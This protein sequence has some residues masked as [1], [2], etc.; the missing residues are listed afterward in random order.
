MFLCIFLSYLWFL[1]AAECTFLK[2]R[3]FFEGQFWISFLKLSAIQVKC[4]VNT[5]WCCF[6]NLRQRDMH[7]FMFHLLNVQQSLFK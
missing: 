3:L 4:V 6:A 2:D 7:S 5:F 1:V